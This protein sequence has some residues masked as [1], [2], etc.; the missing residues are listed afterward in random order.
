MKRLTCFVVAAIVLAGLALSAPAGENLL[1]D[2][3]F[4]SIKEANQFGHVWTDWLG[5]VYE[6]PGK[7]LSGNVARTGQRSYEIIGDQGGKVRLQSPE[8]VVQPGRYKLSCFIR[9]LSIGKGA[10]SSSLDFSAGIE[11]KFFSLKYAK[12]DKGVAAPVKGTFGWTPVTYVFEVAKETK[13]RQMR[14]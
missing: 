7:F 4:E 12:D 5:W 1:K 2:P 8:V 9:G 3:S 6:P 11:G 13:A 10:Y 14:A